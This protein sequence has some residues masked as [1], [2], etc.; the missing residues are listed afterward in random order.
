MERIV[1]LTFRGS[2]H[3][4]SGRLSDSE[5][6]CTADTLFSALFLEAMAQGKQD[7]LLDAGKSGA[8]LISDAFPWVDDICYLP[9]PYYIP[10]EKVTEPT[11]ENSNKQDEISDSITK[12]ALKNLS[13][14]APNDYAAFFGGSFDPK[15]TQES[16]RALGKGDAIT[17]V[18]LARENRNEAE[19]YQVGVFRFKENAG[20]YFIVRGTYDITP[21]LDTLQYSG[22]GGKRSAGYGRFTYKVSEY[23]FSCAIDALAD[24]Q[25]IL[26]SSATPTADELADELL[27]DAAYS[28]QRRSGFVQSEN[29]APTF[30][31]KRDFYV[32]TAGSTFSHKFEGYVFDVG[33]GGAHHVWRYAKA[34]WMEG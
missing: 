7:D 25:N 29:Y 3:F 2:V 6:T 13:Y 24:Q 22:L 16:L 1:K 20:L 17:K 8:L 14:I 27:Q 5:C 33:C 21:L 34:F 4:G 11:K 19:P 32:F 10:N 23:D 12:K 9:K 31:K 30:S 18:N 28:L 15:T 26:L